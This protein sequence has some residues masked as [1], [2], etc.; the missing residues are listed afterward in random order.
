MDWL[1]EIIKVIIP[2]GLMVLLAYVLLSQYFDGQL[3][4]KSMELQRERKKDSLGLR[5]NAYERLALYM[6]RIGFPDMIMRVNADRMEAYTL[7]TSLLMTI[8]KE[9][10]HNLSQQ[11]YI[12]ENL[13]KII[14]LSK[15]ELANLITEAYSEDQHQS[16]DEYV[17]RLLKKYAEWQPNPVESAKSA[18][19]QEAS[20]LL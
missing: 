8:Q 15:Q 18:V 1:V 5:L 11:V 7:Y 13:W 2:M 6:E 10:E 9:Y 4:L 16:K 3:R 17:N 14:R 12:S 20:I 19:R